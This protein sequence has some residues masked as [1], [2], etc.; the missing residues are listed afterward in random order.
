V[1]VALALVA[2]APDLDLLLGEHREWTHSVGAAVIA[3]A[4]AFAIT[5]RWR[6]GLAVALA[7]TSHVFL[8]WLSSDS[9]PPIG[10]MA[11]WP[12]THAYYKAPIEIFP[13]VSRRYWLAE[14]WFYNVKAAAVEIAVLLPVMLLSMYRSRGRSS[15]RASPP[16]P[17]GGAADTGDTSD[18]RGRR[19]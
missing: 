10:V 1:A 11:F 19:G 9:R 7:W 5:R 4:I 17:S 15:A 13:A 3:G 2:A 14:F 8:D 16:P 12:L 6:W 18:R